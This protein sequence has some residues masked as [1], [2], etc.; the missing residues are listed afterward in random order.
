MV[1]LALDVGEQ[2]GRILGELVL[3]QQ[4][5]TVEEAEHAAVPAATVPARERAPSGGD[6]STNVSWS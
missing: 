4:C 2:L 1:D 6:G 3:L 5:L